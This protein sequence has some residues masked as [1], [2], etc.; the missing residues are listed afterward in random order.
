MQPK[1]NKKVLAKC[2]TL[3]TKNFARAGLE[4]GDCHAGRDSASTSAAVATDRGSRPGPGLRAHHGRS[5]RPRLC[6]DERGGGCG[7][8]LAFGLRACHG[9]PTTDTPATLPSS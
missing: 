4:P 7:S 1:Q 8:G 2:N 9:Q 5:R 3:G 6:L